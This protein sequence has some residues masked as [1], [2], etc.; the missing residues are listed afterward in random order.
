MVDRRKLLD[1][2][3]INILEQ[4]QENCLISKGEI[5]EKCQ[6]ASE[7][8]VSYRI[9]R[10][11]NEGIIQG[12]HAQ[13]NLASH[14]EEF[15]TCL[16]IASKI[17]PNYIQKMENV[18]RNIPEVWGVYFILGQKNF[19]VMAKTANQADFMKKVYTILINS[20]LVTE[21]ETLVVSKII[22]EDHSRIL[23]EKPPK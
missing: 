21:I 8:T 12:Y 7:S 2:I 14:Q 18:L 10:L 4:L 23:F 9:N 11:E 6:I 15:D 13:I 20:H 22:K 1:D 3:D 16:L 19:L 5:A 17:E